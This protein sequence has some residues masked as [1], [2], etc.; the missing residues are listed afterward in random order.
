MKYFTIFCF[1]FLCMVGC[2]KESEPTENRPPT[3]NA[4]EDKNI[5]VNQ[6][7]KLLGTAT[8]PDDDKLT[9]EWS[10]LV[11]PKESKATIA[12]KS[13]INTNF[14]ADKAGEYLLQLKVTD[15]KVIVVD[16]VKFTAEANQ[17]PKIT[18]IP[19]Q[20]ATINQKL[21]VYFYIFDDLPQ[22]LILT[23]KSSNQEL[24]KDESIKTN[25]Y[26]TEY[27]FKRRF[28]F[29]EIRPE[30]KIG[31]L[32]I[33]ITATDLKGQQ[34]TTHFPL[35]ITKQPD[36]IS[37]E[38][39]DIYDSSS[40]FGAD[41]AVFD[42]YMIVGAPGEHLIGHFLR[43]GDAYILKRKG[44]TWE[45]QYKFTHDNATEFSRLGNTVAMTDKYAF[46]GENGYDR[47]GGYNGTG[48]V[49]ILERVN[50]KWIKK[51]KLLPNDIALGDHFGSSID[52]SGNHL[53]V[54]APSHGE[55]GAI[56]IFQLEDNEW[57]QD[58]KITLDQHIIGRHSVDLD[59]NKAIIAGKTT[60]IFEKKNGTWDYQ[61]RLNTPSHSVLLSGKHAIL[62]HPNIGDGVVHT[63]YQ[64]GNNWIQQQ[65]LTIIESDESVQDPY[66]DTITNFGSSIAIYD[67]Y[68]IIGAVGRDEENRPPQDY[69]NGQAYIFQYAN[70]KWIQRGKLHSTGTE[71]NF[72]IA[73][74][75]SK[76]NI[77]I[78]APSAYLGGASRLHIYPK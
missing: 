41:F 49:W 67:D 62:G 61:A 52:V 27:S 66:V 50:D 14:I 55:Y 17:P 31:N 60:Y 21:K 30:N 54:S 16:K 59:G 75:M 35:S 53:I 15:G 29:M 46:I 34:Y 2:S 38:Y 45:Q 63:F 7:V 19:D 72:G 32:S 23:T 10:I 40:G 24:V 8:D 69:V 4:G 5:L 43:R 12:L 73:V 36:I 39:H 44:K 47:L 26:K 78:G 74:S 33:E 18:E 28:A 56:Y 68:M 9:Y 64:D 25:I 37:K 65:K 76:D 77:F 3:V 11:K 22:D 58:Q 57:I 42:D 70:K 48:V 1:I 6:T 20:R 71:G 13:Q 51:S